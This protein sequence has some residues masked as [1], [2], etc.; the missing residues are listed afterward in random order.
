MHAAILAGNAA[1]VT[2]AWQLVTLL[3]GRTREFA[4]LSRDA[5]L[6]FVPQNVRRAWGLTVPPSI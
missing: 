2:Q 4:G 5:A 6:V 1:G 3:F